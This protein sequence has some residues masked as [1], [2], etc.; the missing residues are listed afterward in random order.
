M[1]KLTIKNRK[2]S[3]RPR[4]RG[5]S[6]NNNHGIYVPKWKA[7]TNAEKRR[8][9]RLRIQPI[10]NSLSDADINNCNRLLCQKEDDTESVKL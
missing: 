4:N 2:L 9:K 6:S 7:T 5:D 1:T 3:N 10:C 8:L